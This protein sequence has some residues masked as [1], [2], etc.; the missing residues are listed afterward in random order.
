MT[1]SRT[2]KEKI[3]KQRALGWLPRG[4]TEGRPRWR[5]TISPGHKEIHG[6]LKSSDMVKERV[7]AG[8]VVKVE[9]GLAPSV[10]KEGMNH[11]EEMQ[12]EKW[13]DVSK[14]YL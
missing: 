9:K 1:I 12:P 6:F 13:R 2:N 5:L 10:V 3:E 7:A 8:G 4:L 14:Y 11:A